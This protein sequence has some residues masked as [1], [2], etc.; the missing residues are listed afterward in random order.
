MTAHPSSGEL[1]SDKSRSNYDNLETKSVMHLA[2]S[3]VIREADLMSSKYNSRF[4]YKFIDPDSHISP[5]KPMRP[6][7]A[8]TKDGTG[9]WGYKVPKSLALHHP[10]SYSIKKD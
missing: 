2:P 8:Y 7:S 4:H 10:P 1:L 9:V 6:T 5:V 3:V